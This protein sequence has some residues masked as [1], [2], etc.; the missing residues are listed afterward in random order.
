MVRKGSFGPSV[1]FPLN[2]G[3]RLRRTGLLGR[4]TSEPRASSEIDGEVSV[5]L[6]SA[7]FAKLIVTGTVRYLG[8][9]LEDALAI[10]EAVEI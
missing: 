7:E 9:N 1:R 4:A 10:S 3:P 5:E 2:F 8:V 6:H